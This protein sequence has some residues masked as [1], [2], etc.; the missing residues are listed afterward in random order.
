[1]NQFDP[2]EWHQFGVSTARPHVAAREYCPLLPSAPAFFQEGVY[3][4]SRYACYLRAYRKEFLRNG[5]RVPALKTIRQLLRL[6]TP[7][8]IFSSFAKAA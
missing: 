4:V 5:L 3:L 6:E 8:Q 7:P 2:E 1:M